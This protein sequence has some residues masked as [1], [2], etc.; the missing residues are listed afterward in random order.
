[1]EGSHSLTKI[2]VTDSTYVWGETQ[3]TF[4]PKHFAAVSETSLPSFPTENV[5]MKLLK[6]LI[7]ASSSSKIVVW[8]N[9]TAAK[10]SLLV[11]LLHCST[12]LF[13]KMQQNYFKRYLSQVY[14]FWPKCWVKPKARSRNLKLLRPLVFNIVQFKINNFPLTSRLPFCQLWQNINLWKGGLHLLKSSWFYN[15]KPLLCFAIT[16][17]QNI[18]WKSETCINFLKFCF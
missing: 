11:T 16:L 7:A 2:V 14:H 13:L 10:V 9:I 12:N 6:W 5:Q 1:M 3:L 18:Y 15:S 8:W 4:S 17:P